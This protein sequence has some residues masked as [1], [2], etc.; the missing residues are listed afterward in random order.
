MLLTRAIEAIGG[1]EKCTPKQKENLRELAISHAQS[2][3]IEGLG[4]YVQS[5]ANTMSVCDNTDF[6]L[7]TCIM[8]QIIVDEYRQL[9]HPMNKVPILQGYFMRACAK[10]SHSDSSKAII[11]IDW[12]MDTFKNSTSNFLFGMCKWSYQLYER[13]YKEGSDTFGA[14][15]FTML[16]QKDQVAAVRVMIDLQIKD[17]E[18]ILAIRAGAANTNNIIVLTSVDTYEILRKERPAIFSRR[19]LG[20]SEYLHYNDCRFHL[21][22]DPGLLVSQYP[23]S[24]ACTPTSLPAF[25]KLAGDADWFS[26]YTQGQSVL[27]DELAL[28]ATDRKYETKVRQEIADL[29]RAVLDKDEPA[30]PLHLSIWY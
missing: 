21:R 28:K 11:A 19:N 22:T 4:Q 15:L 23:T 8:K 14:N 20:E 9:A 25:R 5:L 13:L 17:Q 6:V 29:F 12:F 10:L 1:S 26:R 2:P 16:V 24:A 30:E 27:A 3:V 7:V 18:I